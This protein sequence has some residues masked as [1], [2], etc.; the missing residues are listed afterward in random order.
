MRD[1][2]QVQ[3]R[4]QGAIQKSMSDVDERISRAEQ[5]TRREEQSIVDEVTSSQLTIRDGDINMQSL[6]MEINSL[7]SLVEEQ[8]RRAGDTADMQKQIV[9]ALDNLSL[10]YTAGT[11]LI[12]SGRLHCPRLF[13]LW[14]VRSRRGI[15]SELSIATEYQLI[16][17][18]ARD[19]SPVSSPV[20]IKDAKKWLKQAAPL[21]KFALFSIRASAAA[22]GGIPVPS[23]PDCIVGESLSDRWYRVLREM[24]ILLT[25]EDIRS[26]EEWMDGAAGGHSLN[27]AIAMLEGDIPEEAYEALL[28]EAYKPMNRGW[29]DEME[30][31]QRDKGEFAWVKKENGAACRSFKA[32]PDFV[33][34]D[35]ELDH[36][37][38]SQ[39]GKTVSHAALDPPACESGTYTSRPDRTLSPEARSSPTNQLPGTDAAHREDRP[40]TGTC[41]ENQP[42]TEDRLPDVGIDALPKQRAD[43]DFEIRRLTAVRDACIDSPHE[44]RWH[45]GMAA[46]KKI[47]LMTNVI[48]SGRYPTGEEL[49]AAANKLTGDIREMVRSVSMEAATPLRERLL[50]VR[51]DL[52]REREAEARVREAMG[53]STDS[54]SIIEGRRAVQAVLQAS[55]PSSEVG[56]ISFE[57]LTA[58]TKDWKD[59]IGKG[60]FG[61]VYKG[62]DSTSG[63]LVAVKTISRES[64]DERERVNYMKEMEVCLHVS[65]RCCCR[66]RCWLLTP[67]L[68]ALT[69]DLVLASSPK[70]CSNFGLR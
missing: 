68:P 34:S 47:R 37:P 24:E 21:V 26:L 38:A 23:L 56:Q 29:M 54:E 25:L 55:T 10:T 50:Q 41:G 65:S 42:G 17:L 49:E 20:I 67:R 64:L 60:G 14:P 12:A 18:C 43:L 9:A 32:S 16:F 57:Y 22:C 28:E 52:A 70:Y 39:G 31:A 2:V 8:R 3:L 33:T 19:M 45:E 6:D 36:P 7:K 48:S 69:P 5:N 27:L 30:I 13:L 62:Q 66:C 61:V 4:A 53:K 35:R 58:I 63:V 40:P 46:E 1:K 51:E 59:R 15:R 44:D 11:Q